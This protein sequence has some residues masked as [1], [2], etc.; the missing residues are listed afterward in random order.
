MEKGNPASDAHSADRGGLPHSHTT[1]ARCV[2]GMPDLKLNSSETQL[3]PAP[4]PVS[5]RTSLPL[6]LLKQ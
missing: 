2:H 5:L 3:W 4:S 6:E 1:A